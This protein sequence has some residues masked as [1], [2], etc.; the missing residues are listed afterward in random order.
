MVCS[1]KQCIYAVSVN[2]PLKYDRRD[3]YLPITKSAQDEIRNMLYATLTNP[4]P[5]TI[6]I[7]PKESNKCRRIGIK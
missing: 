5:C 2:I 4:N 1:G 6:L 3:I 7:K